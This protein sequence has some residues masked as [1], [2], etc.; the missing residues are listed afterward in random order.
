MENSFTSTV[1]DIGRL[2]ET[3]QM[4]ERQ[5]NELKERQH[6]M[7]QEVAELKARIGQLEK[8]DYE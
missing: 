2:I 8:G 5:I 3:V 6:E 1:Q 4:Q 7:T